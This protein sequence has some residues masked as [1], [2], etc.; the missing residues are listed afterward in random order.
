MKTFKSYFIASIL[1]FTGTITS[2]QSLTEGDNLINISFGLGNLVRPQGFTT[3]IPPTVFQYERA[4]SSKITFGGYLGYSASYFEDE[5]TFTSIYS[6]YPTEYQQ[7]RWNAKNILF[8][9]KGT[10]HLG[11]ELNTSKK[12]DPYVG[13]SLGYNAT[14]VVLKQLEGT[15]NQEPVLSPAPT[16][17]V[18][19]GIFIGVRYYVNE[20]VSFFGEF[21]Y[22]T[23]VLQLGI[24]FKVK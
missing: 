14:T 21:G 16:S 12:L 2:A 8:G 23:A 18:M 7:Y 19:V 6:P 4:L 3:V 22:S 17:H 13:L 5:G 9:I 11:E 15:F 20:K 24:S 1:L 10:Y